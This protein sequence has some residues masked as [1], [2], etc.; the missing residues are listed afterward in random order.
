M[1]VADLH[2]HTTVSDGQLAPEAVP[3]AAAD[4][5]LSAVAITDH[6]RI[7]PALSAPV[8]DREGV[9]VI[10]GIE[11]RVET[12]GV[13]CDRVDLLGYAVDPTDRLRDLCADIQRDRVDRAERIVD[14]V[15]DRL[16]VSLDIDLGP[17]VGRPHVA[18]A[19]D[20]SDAETTYGEAFE[21][22]IGDDGPCYVSRSIPDFETGREV[23]SDACAVVGL[24]HPFRYDD[25]AA[26]LSLTDRLDAVEGVYP[27]AEDPDTT[28]LTEAIERNDLLVTGGSDAHGEV[29]GGTGLDRPG[30]DA[31]RAALPRSVDG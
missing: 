1:V 15:E 6:D 7:N 10:N 28:P 30:Y 31:V 25:P 13:D 26:A 22:L 9:T 5:G 20:D 11:L 4:A 8:R 23:L 19:I 17:G 16:G 18:R 21:T 3:A 29:V 27:Y 12:P 2:V 24:A 14:C